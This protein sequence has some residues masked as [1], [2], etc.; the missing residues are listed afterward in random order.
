MFVFTESVY[1]RSMKSIT[2]HVPEEVDE[3]EVRMQLAALLFEKGI[4]SSGQAAD[5][6]GVS[7]RFF[8]ENVG[9]YGVSV[10]G[11]TADDIRKTLND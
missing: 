2:V 11:E 3:A 10:F 7:K 9:K 6:A 1:L 4:M 5:V 8:L